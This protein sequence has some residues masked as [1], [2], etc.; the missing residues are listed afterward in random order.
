ML[1]PNEASSFT[2]FKPLQIEQP[3]YNEISISK[4]QEYNP[5]GPM[6][7]K[8]GTINTMRG[9]DGEV[10]KEESSVRSVRMEISE[11]ENSNKETIKLDEKS[12]TILLEFE[13]GA[14]LGDI[15]KR[16]K[17]EDDL[18]SVVSQSRDKD[19]SSFNID[20]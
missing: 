15:K 17:F 4:G 2:S 18:S 16:I 14:T 8:L 12:T 7:T 3:L 6:N 9:D 13:E 1:F 5:I 19:N 11:D 20:L 10:D